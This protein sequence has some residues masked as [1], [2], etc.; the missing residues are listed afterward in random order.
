MA[1]YGAEQMSAGFRAMNMLAGFVRRGGRPAAVAPTIPLRAGEKQY[2]WLPVTVDRGRRRI[3]VITNLRLIVGEEYP[4]WAI[5]RVR[6]VPGEWS[7]ALEFRG[8]EP[9]VLGGP[10]VPWLSVVICA[11]LYG[12]AWPPVFVPSQRTRRGA[13][14]ACPVRR[15]V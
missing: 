5:T 2:G 1:E 11:E 9:I 15:T 13:V 10:W 7:V 4:L 3:A 8:R 14:A 6:P 12:T